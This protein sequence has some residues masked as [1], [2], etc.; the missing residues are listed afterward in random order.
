[1]MDCISKEL[2][3][4]ELQIPRLTG[5]IRD[6]TTRL[7]IK[8]GVGRIWQVPTKELTIWAQRRHQD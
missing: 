2:G 3:F 1:M 6:L 7:S 8:C 5:L 4:G